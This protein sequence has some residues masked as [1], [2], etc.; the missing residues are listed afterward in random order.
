M[1]DRVLLQDTSRIKDR[2]K[3]TAIARE[4]QTFNNFVVFEEDKQADGVG[5]LHGRMLFGGPADLQGGLH[6]AGRGVRPKHVQGGPV[7]SR[8]IGHVKNGSG[9]GGSLFD[10]RDQP[11][12]RTVGCQPA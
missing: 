11:L 9:V 7:E 1:E 5:V 12:L 6:L 3:I 10:C 2:Q 8:H 4:V